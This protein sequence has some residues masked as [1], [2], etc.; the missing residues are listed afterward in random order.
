MII[1]IFTGDAFLDAGI[2]V[3]L[4][5]AVV[6]SFGDDD[7]TRGSSSTSSFRDLEEFGSIGI[8]SAADRDHIRLQ[9]LQTL[10]HRPEE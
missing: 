3:G 10:G 6:A 7:V 2:D 1:T 9:I 5:S 8:S 4:V